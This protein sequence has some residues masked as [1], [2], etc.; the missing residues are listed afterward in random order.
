MPTVSFLIPTYNRAGFLS[1]CIESILCQSYRDFEIIVIDDGSTDNTESLIKERYSGRIRYYKSAFNRGVAFSRNTALGYA[2]GRYLALLDSDDILYT[3]DYI[4]TVLDILES[5]PSIGVV[6]C[7]AYCIDRDGNNIYGQTFFQTTIDHRDIILSSGIKDFDYIFFHGI[8]SCG[9]LIRRG[10]IDEVGFLNTDY[11]IA[12][13]EDFFLRVAANPIYKIYY[14]NEPLVGYRIHNGSISKN[15]SLLY[16]EKI[17]C[18]LNA[19]NQNKQIRERLG[20]K[21]N[22]RIAMQ[23]FCLADAYKKEKKVL[24]CFFSILKLISINPFF[25]LDIIKN[26]I[27]KIFYESNVD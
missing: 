16:R 9:A 3:P 4:K 2:K 22:K 19:L 15:L 7:D 8:H 17:R 10:V 5:D 27:L 1:K 13:D 25:V 23:Y 6:G 14:Y 26:K 11:K 24:R 20:M 18:R 12:W 21:A